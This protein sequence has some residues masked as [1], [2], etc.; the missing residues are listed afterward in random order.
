MADGRL[1]I[2]DAFLKIGSSYLRIGPGTFAIFGG[3]VDSAGW[4]TLNFS[5]NNGRG[6]EAVAVLFLFH[7]DD[8]D[9]VVTIGGDL[10]WTLLDSGDNGGSPVTTYA[11]IYS[12]DVPSGSSTVSIS[13]PNPAAG[14]VSA[15]VYGLRAGAG[16][17]TGANVSTSTDMGIS[18]GAGEVI[19]TAVEPPATM[20][21]SGYTQGNQLNSQDNAS[22]VGPAGNPVWDNLPTGIGVAAVIEPA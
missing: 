7:G 17:V 12:A 8:E 19:I 5:I 13:I 14:A 4:D 11:K 1:K 16:S 6:V 9:Q 20:L 10:T 15:A 2:G 3:D 21:T 22:A 18:P